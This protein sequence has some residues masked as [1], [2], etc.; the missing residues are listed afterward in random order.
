MHS[1]ANPTDSLANNWC[2]PVTSSVTALAYPTSANHFNPHGY[3]DV[4][5]S[6]LHPYTSHIASG[7]ESQIY[8]QW[9]TWIF[10]GIHINQL[11]V[12]L[13]TW[14]WLSNHVMND[15]NYVLQFQVLRGA[16]LMRV[17]WHW[18]WNLA[19]T[20]QRWLWCRW[21]TTKCRRHSDHP[22]QQYN[23]KGQHLPSESQRR[24]REREREREFNNHSCYVIIERQTYYD[25]K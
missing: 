15:T 14:N 5:K 20:R 19:S 7:M 21:R 13:V 12:C 6:T 11:K 4:T 10:V 24:E 23:N 22:W 17:L 2:S 9:Q 8:Y 1:L 3:S 25:L 18:G 16:P